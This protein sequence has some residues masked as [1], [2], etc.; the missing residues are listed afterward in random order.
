[1]LWQ[2][3]LKKEEKRKIG[4]ETMV[5]TFDRNLMGFSADRD[6]SSFRKKG[7]TKRGKLETLLGFNKLL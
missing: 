1:M 5:G 4:V 6:V 3:W 7:K 2:R